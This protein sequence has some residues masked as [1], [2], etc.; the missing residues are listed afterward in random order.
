MS[1]NILVT[2]G[3]GYIGSH[4]CVELINAGYN[5]II[6]DNFSNSE[7]FIIQRIEEITGHKLKVLE[8]D[9]S[10]EEF[11]LD[12]LKDIELSG[13]IHFAA[14]KAV[15]E[16]TRLPLKYYHNNIGSLVSILSVMEKLNSPNFVFSSSCTVYGQP[17]QL[18]VTEKSPLKVAES[19]YGRTKQ[20]CEDIINDC[21]LSGMNLRALALRYFNPIGA[22][23][24]ALIG[25][26]PI[27][28]PNNLVPFITQT[29]IGKR[30]KLTVYGDDYNTKDGT[31]V[32]DYIH[33]V[34]LAKAHIAA[35]DYL[36][37]QK[38][39]MLDHVNIGTG[40]GNSVLEV[41]TAFEQVNDITLNYEIGPRREGDV[42]KVYADGSYA[43]SIL[44]WKTELG[45]KDALKDA[46]RWQMSLS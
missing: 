31:C 21:F 10:D 6:V 39:P 12:N 35:I 30:E 3:A 45:L 24:S 32:R 9:C 5:P 44:N 36:I 43:K 34:D 2:G 13:C 25:E 16:S 23:P 28:V 11:L 38:N 41:I 17:D 26:L 42:E 19:P 29:A 40:N 33:V 37:T 15:G 8:G 22:H 1:K 7:K 27:G 14:F 20:M 46:W 4:T 18:P